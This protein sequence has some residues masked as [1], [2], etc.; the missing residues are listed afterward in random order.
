MSSSPET[1]VAAV[2][3]TLLQYRDISSQSAQRGHGS[4]DDPSEDGQERD[5]KE[6]A[7]RYTAEQVEAEIARVRDETAHEVECRLIADFEQKLNATRETVARMIQCFDEQKD[8]YFSRVEAEVIQL[9]LS[10]ARK[11][12]HREAQVDPML[13]AALVRIA[14][15]KVQEG[16]SVTIRVGARRGAQ[17]RNYLN[18]EPILAEVEIVEDQQLSDFD[19]IVDTNLGTANFSLDEQLKEV[20]QGFFDLL[21]L[22]PRRP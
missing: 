13:V 20:E 8:E 12:L 21:A 2:P 3:V 6:V 7:L 9:S 15:E 11:I 10:I 5:G 19:C 4:G 22:K 16:S 14:L 1:N 18:G 17:W